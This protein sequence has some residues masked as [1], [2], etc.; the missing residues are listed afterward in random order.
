MWNPFIANLKLL[1]KKYNEASQLWSLEMVKFT[2]K[3]TISV[4]CDHLLSTRV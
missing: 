4:P 1:W 2:A 3:M